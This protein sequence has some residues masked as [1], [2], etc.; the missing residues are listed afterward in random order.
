[1]STEALHYI[2]QCPAQCLHVCRIQI[3]KAAA[4][5]SDEALLACNQTDAD[6]TNTLLYHYSRSYSTAG[7]HYS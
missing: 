5:Q 7:E 4:E 2:G 6:R 3:L 1:M